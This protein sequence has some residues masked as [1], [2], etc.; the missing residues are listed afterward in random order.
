M[1]RYTF[2]QLPNWIRK[3]EARTEYIIKASAQRLFEDAQT[4]RAKGGLMPVDT[5]FLRNTF[6]AQVG[7]MPS[8]PGRA[9]DGTPPQDWQAPVALAIA[10]TQP[11]DVLFAGWTARYARPME[12]RYAFMRS[13][14]AR[15][16]SFVDASVREARARIG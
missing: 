3:C 11:G 6:A 8:G 2:A 13:S 14:A 15:W 10:Q 5:A 4:P 16:Q 1:T 12:D 9:G 7:Q